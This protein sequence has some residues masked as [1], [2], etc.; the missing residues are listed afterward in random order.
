MNPFGIKLRFCSFQSNIF[1]LKQFSRCNKKLFKKFRQGKEQK[2]DP[3]LYMKLYKTNTEPKH[4]GRQIVKIQ[5]FPEQVLI[6][7]QTCFTL[8]LSEMAQSLRP[9]ATSA[10][11][12]AS[13][14]NILCVSDVDPD[15]YGTALWETSCS[16]IQE[17]KNVPKKWR[18]IK[19]L[20]TTLWGAS[21][22]RIHM[23]VDVD[24]GSGSALKSMRIHITGTGY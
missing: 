18:Q 2:L 13:T 8:S 6:F 24:L 10:S 12:L 16:R 21:W 19:Y 3:D 9:F 4:W 17:A 20:F 11:R 22:F 1:F 7:L 5:H 15:P 23:N 14:A